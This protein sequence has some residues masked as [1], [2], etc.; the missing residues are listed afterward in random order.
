MVVAGLSAAEF[1]AW[2]LRIRTN[3]DAATE[4]NVRDLTDA[5]FPLLDREPIRADA[6]YAEAVTLTTRLRATPPALVAALRGYAE[7]GRANALRMRGHYQEAMQLLIDAEQ[8]FVDA[9]YCTVEIGA[10]RYVRASV[11]FKM[12]RW[13]EAQEAAAQ[14]RNI[15]EEEHDRTRALHARMIEGCVLVERGDLDAARAI[16]VAL[17]KP[18][19]NN[20]HRDALA[21]VYMNLGACD[22]RRREPKIARHW[23]SRAT[24]LLRAI[25]TPS[26]LV[27]ARWCG[28]KI[29]IFDGERTRGMRELRAVMQEF[30]RLSMPADAGFAGLDLLEAL[31]ADGTATKEA[32]QLARSLAEFFIAAGVTV[33]AARAIGYLRDAVAAQ[34]ADVPLV[35]YVRRYMHR[36][37]VDADYPFTPPKSGAEPM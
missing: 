9:G 30:E 13:Q 20:R 19:S 12:Q 17:L 15:F 16:L 34:T 8:H 4:A 5:A 27:R 37:E 24:Q 25:G 18:L 32:E 14:A 3:A 28:A 10:V 22:L 2:L 6:L 23:L 33:S 1:D 35:G 36:A 21:R 31:L 11:L 26:E 29:T 7:K